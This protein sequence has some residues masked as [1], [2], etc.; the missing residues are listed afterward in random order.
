MNSKDSQA[1][2]NGEYSSLD[3]AWQIYHNTQNMIRYADQKVHVLIVLGIIITGAV[4][5]Q[6]D[7]L[8]R[9]L[10]TD[11][12]LMGSFFI[13]TG[14]FLTST[15]LALVSKFDVKSDSNVPKLVFFRHIQKRSQALEYSDAF[16]KT[17]AAD[18]LKDLCY[19]IYEVSVISEKKFKYYRMACSFIIIHLMI[20]LMIFYRIS[21][22]LGS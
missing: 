11:R 8:P 21:V 20:F 18:V 14:F 5:T 10:A 13:S 19:Q 22:I 17:S 1:A 6:L 16:K 12:I 15:M 2:K 4:I 3:H 9:D 7:H